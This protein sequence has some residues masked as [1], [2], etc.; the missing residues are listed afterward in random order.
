MELMNVVRSCA[1]ILRFWGAI[2]QLLNTLLHQ[3]L[4]FNVQTG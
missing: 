2:A 1:T 4:K 3:N